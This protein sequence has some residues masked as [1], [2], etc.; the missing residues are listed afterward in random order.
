M[1]TLIVNNKLSCQ[2]SM[3]TQ[4]RKD[5]SDEKNSLILTIAITLLLSAFMVGCGEDEADVDTLDE[6]DVQS[7]YK[8]LVGTYDLFKLE[9]SADGVKLVLEPPS[10]AGTMTI[11]SDQKITRK[12]KVLESSNFIRVS[13]EILLDEGVMS[14]M[15]IDFETEEVISKYTWDGEILT[16]TVDDGTTVGTQFWR[17]LNNSVIDL[18]PPELESEPEP[19]PSAAFVSANP[20]SGSKIAAN[21]TVILTFDNAPTDVTVSAGFLAGSGKT[22][23]VAGPFPAGPLALTV[24]WA[25][26]SV[27]LTYIVVVLDVDPPEVTGGTVRDGDKD[28]DPDVLFEDGIEITFSEDIAGDIELQ[29]EA[30][31]DVRWIGWIDGDKARLEAVAGAEL[32]N[33]TIYVIKGKVADAAGNETEISITFVT[34]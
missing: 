1:K 25:D 18:Q 7:L 4:H 15:S 5:I 32:N 12:F 13:F 19:P 8:E 3:R 14:I 26:G 27:T 11:S 24:T 30:G 6:T 31:D 20:P 23:R 29:T 10:I 22:L 33:K 2:F 9:G 28:V 34:R 21:A 17:K 16:M